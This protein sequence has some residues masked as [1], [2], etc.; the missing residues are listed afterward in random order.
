MVPLISSSPGFGSAAELPPGL[1][2]DA[3]PPDGI[4]DL[5]FLPLEPQPVPQQQ[6][7][8]CAAPDE[9]VPESDETGVDPQQ[10]LS[11]MLNQQAVQ[12]QARGYSD[13]RPALS[14]AMPGVDRLLS[15]MP[16]VAGAMVLG[17]EAGDPSEH[18]V[19]ADKAWQGTQEV[20]AQPPQR[21]ATGLLGAWLQVGLAPQAVAAV[22][23]STNEVPA[24]SASEGVPLAPPVTSLSAPL[25]GATASQA[26]VL[27]RGLKLAAP[28][29]RWGEQM[30]HA[31]RE[32]V[33]VQVQQRF[34]QAT[35]R[36]DPPELGS[37]EIFITHEP[38]RLSV[39]ISAV[40]GDVAR[41]LLHT[42]DRLR[43]E[44]VEQNTLQVSVEI[45]SDSQGH[46]GRDSSRQRH[47]REIAE[48]IEDAPGEIH[49]KKHAPGD[50]LVTV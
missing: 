45:S 31:L 19:A 10:W 41:L 35:I 9:P 46:S 39:Q 12:L 15:R 5:L 27:E 28:Q 16:M 42:S 34:Q 1:P 6:W 44:L 13:A 47:E 4:A 3:Q 48:A 20:L 36:L 11:A 43:Q 17:Q 2:T 22:L 26:P 14:D 23:P 8:D 38:G 33:Q 32:T 30:L 40:Q 18:K 7:C 50:V 21:K 25:V 37:L 24:M 29:A 49:S